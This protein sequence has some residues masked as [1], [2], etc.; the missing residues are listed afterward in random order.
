NFLIS[1]QGVPGLVASDTL[2]AVTTLSF[3]IAGLEIYLPLITGGR[4]ILASR[5][6]AADGKQLLKLMQLFGP[7]LM[8]ATPATW[9]ILIEAGWSGSPTLKLLCGGEALPGDLSGQLLPRC[10]VLWNIAGAM[11]TGRWLWVGRADV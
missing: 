1:M 9:R 3:D 6:E 4:I 11:E 2:L 10:R 8:Q 7:T 5:E